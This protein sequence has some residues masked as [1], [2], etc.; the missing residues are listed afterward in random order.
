MKW[1]VA[2]SLS[3][4]SCMLSYLL[5]FLSLSSYTLVFLQPVH[6]VLHMVSRDKTTTL[7]RI[8][9]KHIDLY[10]DI[11]GPQHTT[12]DLG[13]LQQPQTELTVY[14]LIT[15]Q[16]S[17]SLQVC[18]NNNHRQYMMPVAFNTS[19]YKRQCQLY[20]YNHSKTGTYTITQHSSH[21]QHSGWQLFYNSQDNHSC[22]RNCHICPNWCH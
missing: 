17:R 15:F 11:T 18:N 4:T 10:S 13:E 19:Y 3:V 2:R 21:R 1:S 7:W 5:R 14:K 16:A 8:C 20:Q 9:C 22:L 6:L 12:L